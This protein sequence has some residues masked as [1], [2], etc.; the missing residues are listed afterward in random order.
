MSSRDVLFKIGTSSNL[1]DM[2]LNPLDK[3]KINKTKLVIALLKK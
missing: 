1:A 3:S 2:T